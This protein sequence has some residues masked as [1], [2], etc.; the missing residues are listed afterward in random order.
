V[1][2]HFRSANYD[3]MA[4]MMKIAEKANPEA[5][6]NVRFGYHQALAKKYYPDVAAVKV[7]G[8]PEA[9]LT[10]VIERTSYVDYIAEQVVSNGKGSTH[11]P[12]V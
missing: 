6:D 11:T 12:T 4:E 1:E 10:F 9:P 7:S 2:E 3:P 5:I 8:D